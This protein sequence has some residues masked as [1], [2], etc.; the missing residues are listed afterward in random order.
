MPLPPIA[1]LIIAAASG[2]AG[3]YWLAAKIGAGETARVEA[4]RMEC[5]QARAQDA[6]LAAEQAAVLLSRAQ[7]AESQAA[8]RIA[9]LEAASRKKI[10]ETRRD[11]YRLSTGRECLAPALRLRLNAAIAD[12]LPAGAGGAPDAA[13]GSP[14]DPGDGRASTDADIA[15]W[16]LDAARLYDECR[17]RLDAIRTWDEV[18]YGR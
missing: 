3:G 10:E 4:R 17:A 1:A 13:A 15:G 9:A 6:R 16:A 5:E 18:T 2:A 14:A 7:E 12:G 11:L 8:D